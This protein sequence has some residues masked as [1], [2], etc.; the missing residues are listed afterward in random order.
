MPHL[1]DGAKAPSALL[2][3]IEPRALLEFGALLASYPILRTTPRGD[4]HSVLVLPGLGASDTSTR[5]L[6]AFLKERGYD[7]HGWTLGRN[8]GPREG[9]RDALHEQL[10]SLHKSSNRKVSLIGWSLGG[11]YARE[12]AKRMPDSVRLVIT[13]GSPFANPG[14]TAVRRIYEALRGEPMTAATDFTRFR[15]PPPVP[16]TAIFS[17]S[18]GVV[19]WQS[20]LEPDSP[21]T[22]NIEVEGSHVGLGVNPAALYVIA[23]RLAQGENEWAPF[24]R[25]GLRG[26]VFKPAQK[27]SR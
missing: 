19:A 24:D 13:L 21:Q 2:T 20:C 10:K 3:L 8:V 17:K 12:I 1:A 16:S 7:A 4:S 18:D 25:S 11:I 14:A 23:D 9:Q 15:A 26:L 22:E 5:P 27:S 6:R